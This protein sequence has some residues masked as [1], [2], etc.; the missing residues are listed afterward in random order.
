MDEGEG[1]NG[2][3]DFLRSL[4]SQIPI[5]SSSFRISRRESILENPFIESCMKKSRQFP[6]LN[7]WGSYPSVRK[8]K[9][10][11]GIPFQDFIFKNLKSFM[12]WKFLPGIMEFF[13]WIPSRGIRLGHIQ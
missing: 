1:I 3:N 11:N 13:L 8:I 5:R 4:S 12:L 2:E 9:E 6:F 10:N 7:F